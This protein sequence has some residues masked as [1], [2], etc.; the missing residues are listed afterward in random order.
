VKRRRRLTHARL[1]ELLHY[2][3][4]TGEFR[5]Q[6]RVGRSVE[7]GA[8]AGLLDSEGYRLITIKGRAYRAHQ[9]AWFYTTG[10]WCR[11][12]IDHRDGD[13]SNNRWSN[14]RRATVSQNNAN[15]RMHRN[16]KCGYK[17][18]TR[19]QWGRFWATIHKAGRRLHLGT[20][21]T[22]QDA[23]AAYMAAARKLF[24]EFARPE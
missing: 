7:A 9:L 12:V 15:R 13:P 20:F 11:T 14:L 5:W 2:D 18:V 19:N 3:S 21:A 8:I 10:K 1:H 24:G 16:N 22:A 23:H 6:E 4:E 17:G